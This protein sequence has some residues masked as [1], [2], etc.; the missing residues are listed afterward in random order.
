M[1]QCSIFSFHMLIERTSYLSFLIHSSE[2]CCL[3]FLGQVH[4]IVILGIS[5]TVVECASIDSF[6]NVAKILD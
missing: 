6:H 5:I 2:A 4:P 1:I 3:L